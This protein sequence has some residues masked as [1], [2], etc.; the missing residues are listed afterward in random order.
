[1]GMTNTIRSSFGHRHD[2][3]NAHFGLPKDLSCTER[4]HVKKLLCWSIILMTAAT[5]G[6]SAWGI[7]ASVKHTDNLV[8][9]FWDVYGQV[10]DTANN[11]YGLLSRLV[12]TVESA[13]ISLNVLVKNNAEIAALASGPL[14]AALINATGSVG[15]AG[16]L[17]SVVDQLEPV[18]EILE[19][20]RQP[21]QEAANVSNE[22]FVQ[23]L[24]GFRDDIEPST[25]VFQ[26]TGRFIAIGVAFGLV[27]LF[28]ILAAAL[29]IWTRWPRLGATSC[30]LLWFMDALLMLLGVGLLNSIKYITEDGCLYA[31]SFVVNLATERVPGDATQYALRAIDYYVDQSASTEYIPGQ[32]LTQIV[33]PVAAQL[34]TISE[35]PEVQAF[36]NQIPIILQAL[37]T[38]T[39]STTV[40]APFVPSVSVSISPETTSALQNLGSQ[41]PDLRD[42]LSDIDETASRHNVLNLYTSAKAYLCCTLS[43]DLSDLYVAWVITG[44]LALVLAILVTWRLVWLTREW[45]PKQ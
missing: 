17:T 14:S 44:V 15:T 37:G 41:I 5:V 6:A 31:E 36:L 32:A 29:T 7:Y 21:L 2:E 12:D 20:V 42:L 10:Q 23:G 39:N 30:I 24:K 27:I 28:A 1:M 19:S 16:T 13:E 8:P 25:Y 26:N 34:L 33:S 35:D 43:G 9:G 38:P 45:Y 22:T 4:F 3:V 40:L 18:S 11:V